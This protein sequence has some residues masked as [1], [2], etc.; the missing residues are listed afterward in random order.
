MDDLNL[1]SSASQL[2]EHLVSLR[3]A[4]RQLNAAQRGAR[5]RRRAKWDAIILAKT[6][7][8]CHI[9]GGELGDDWAADHVLAH[10]GGGA[11]SAE[12]YL[13]AHILCNGYRWNY[14]AE[15]FQWVMK[16]G[17]WARKQMESTS[18]LGPDMLEQFYGYE[19]RRQRRRRRQA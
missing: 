18:G 15:E 1:P 8:L 2:G 3:K 19:V 9:C 12:N 17:I 10:A 5:G 4:R 6:G 16:I 14:L 11:S 13:P 7:G